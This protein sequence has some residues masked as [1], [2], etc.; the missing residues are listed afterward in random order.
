MPMGRS[1]SLLLMQVDGLMDGQR[2]SLKRLLREHGA[3]NMLNKFEDVWTIDRHMITIGC[4]DKLLPHDVGNIQLSTRALL[5]VA[6]QKHIHQWTMNYVQVANTRKESVA[7]NVMHNIK[8]WL[9]LPLLTFVFLYDVCGGA[10][11][12]C[13]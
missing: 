3:P 1:P 5:L 11:D 9:E 10:S 2:P 7:E 12:P 6:Q 4:T 8:E 13:E